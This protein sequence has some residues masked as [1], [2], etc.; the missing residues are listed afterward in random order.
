MP[1]FRPLSLWPIAPVTRVGLLAL[2]LQGLGAG[3]AA[4]ASTIANADEWL[5]KQM[6]PPETAPVV[7]PRAPVGAV[8]PAQVLRWREEATALEHGENGLPRD[9]ARAA[10]LY[11]QA[12]RHG[13]AEAQFALAWMLTNARGIE[14]DEPA[15]A[16]L[17]AAAA[18]QGLPQAVRM[19]GR[20][21]TPLGDPPPC[22]RPPEP[23][24]PKPVAS[25]QAPRTPPAATP[26]QPA[27]P[28]PIT[29]HPLY[30]EAPR[31][32]AEFVRL[33]APDY[34]L[35]PQLVLAVMATESNF[36]PNAVSPKQAQGLMQL[37]PDTAARFKVRN[38]FD[39]AQ[40]IRGGMAYL[41]W[42]LAYFEGDVPLALAAYN[43]GE[44][45]V[46]RYRG[47]PPYAE[48]R[49]YVR[50]VMALFDEAPKLPFDPKLTKPSSATATTRLLR[51]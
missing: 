25:N 6:P 34:Q 36:N 35:P 37:I 8:V 19:A 26:A 40:N 15:A 22:L 29:A 50:K 45:A 12:A 23:E 13:D 41:R 38:I 20:M 39:P 46:D 28:R 30:T 7:L 10:T 47:V 24:P 51:R 17:F 2:A 1:T 49:H 4:Q 31:P 18:E 43:A 16:H 11:C 5:N 42:L 27:G 9:P 48:T 3:L 33:V 14:R 21:G 32:I 44:G